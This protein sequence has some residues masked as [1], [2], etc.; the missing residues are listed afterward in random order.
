MAT[1]GPI[2]YLVME[3]QFP[4][5]CCATRAPAQITEMPG[6]LLAGVL[7]WVRGPGTGVPGD[8]QATACSAFMIVSATAC[9]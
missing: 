5:G 7:V 1:S 6:L 4:L 9:G 2:T 8:D 3:D